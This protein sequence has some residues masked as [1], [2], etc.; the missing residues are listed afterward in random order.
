[1]TVVAE[2]AIRFRD[3]DAFGHVNNAVYATYCE[4][5]RV[6]YFER[7]LDVPVSELDIVVAHL[8]LDYRAPIEGVGTV[9]IEIEAGEPGG[10]SFPLFYELSYEGEVVATGKTIQ[11]AMDESGTPTRVPDS[12]REAIANQS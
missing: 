11:V 7:V 6:E 3:H 2:I 8:E 5:A 4:Q 9:E 10:K 12:W 1:M